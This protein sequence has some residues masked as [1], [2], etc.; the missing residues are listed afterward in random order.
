M[1]NKIILINKE[2]GISS[3]KKIREIQ[4]KYNYSKIGHAGTLDPMAE[5][6]VIAMSDNAT[7]LSDMLMKKDKIY[8]VEMCLYYQTDTLDLEGNIVYTDEEKKIYKE[9]EIIDAMS[10]FIGTSMQKPPMYSAIKLNGLKMYK[11]ARK[12]IEV[13][14]PDRQVNIYYINN[15]KIT[16]DKISFETKVSSGTYIRSLVR[17]IGLKLGTYATMTKLVRTKI[18]NF[19]LPEDVKIMEVDDAINLDKI[20]LDYKQYFAIKNG[21]TCIITSDLYSKDMKLNAYYDDR[22]VGIIEVCDKKNNNNNI[23]IKRT[24]FFD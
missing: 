6:L 17:D 20:V 24:K 22:Y 12:N 5:G 21:M 1:D 7:K 3:Y 10:S 23:Y 16:G 9:E 11:L 14:I 13:D 8:Q 2:K 18:D 19:K 15:I 4:K